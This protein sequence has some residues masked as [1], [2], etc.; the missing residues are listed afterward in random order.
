MS[1]EPKEHL[2]EDDLAAFGF[3]VDRLAAEGS[4]IARQLGAVVA[5]AQAHRGRRRC[6][7]ILRRLC[8][9]CR[10]RKSCQ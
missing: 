8:R 1:D 10:Q 7:L 9:A 6:Q 3:R 5:F 4:D 2:G